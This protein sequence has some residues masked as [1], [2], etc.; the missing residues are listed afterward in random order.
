MGTKQ[1]FRAAIENAGGGGAFVRIPFDVEQVFSSKR[2]KVKATF[3][4]VPYRG[5]LVRMG[6]PF[7]IL[8]VLKGIR[9]QIGKEF[10]DE[11]EVV[12]EAD[13]Q[14]RTVEIPA[15]LAQAL[16]ADPAAGAAFHKLA[17]SHQREYVRAV[18]E[19]KREATRRSRIEKTIA[20]LKAAK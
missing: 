13:T 2:P 4:G 11:V 19:A 14:P 15:D 9:A 18:L 8:I 3:D 12:V 20:A 1:T 6:E 5:T 7:H 10:G 16:D 17:Y